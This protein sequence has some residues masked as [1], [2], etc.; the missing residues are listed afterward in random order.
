[1]KLAS[2]LSKIFCQLKRIVFKR[3]N[4]SKD[5]YC[6]RFSVSIEV[7]LKN[8]LPNWLR[9]STVKSRK[10]KEK[11]DWLPKTWRKTQFP[12]RESLDKTPLDELGLSFFLGRRGLLVKNFIASGRKHWRN[13]IFLLWK[14]EIKPWDWSE[15]L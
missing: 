12:R 6:L 8:S 14:Q 10:W 13:F 7:Y 11:V 9:I 5:S 15:V 2:S 3:K 1:M 4:L